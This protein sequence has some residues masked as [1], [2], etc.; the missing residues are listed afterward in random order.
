CRPAV[1]RVLR[2]RVRGAG[3]RLAHRIPP[4]GRGDVARR[5]GVCGGCGAARGSGHRGR[6]SGRSA[7]VPRAGAPRRGRPARPGP[8][9]RRHGAR[10]A[11]GH[12]G[13][14]RSARLRRGA[15]QRPGGTDRRRDGR[16]ARSVSGPAAV[17]GPW[18]S[19]VSR[20]VP[21]LSRS[22]RPR[23]RP[24]GETAR[25]AAAR[26]PRRPTPDAW[27]VARRRLPQDHDRSRRHGH[28]AVRGDALARGP[29]GGGD[30]PRDAACGKRR[31][32]RGRGPV[33]R[34]L[35]VMP[36]RQ[37][38]RRR[39]AR[40]V[41]L[42][43]AAGAARP[44]GPSALQRRRARGADPAGTS[45]VAGGAGHEELDAI[46]ARLLS[47]LERAERLVADRGSA[48]NL[49]MESFVLLLREGF[50]AILLVA[51][52]MTFLAKAGAVERR[53]HVAQG[54]WAAVGA[55][56]IT[57]VVIELLFQITPGER[58]ALEGFTML[59]AT[60]VLFYVSY[61][62]VSKIEAAKWSAFVK[63]RMEEALSA[64]SGWALASVAFLAVYREGFETILFYKA[65]LTSAGLGGRGGGTTAVLGGVF[66][67]A[68]ALV[69]VYIGINRF[70]LK[71]PL[72]PFFAITS[73]MLYYMAFVFA[74]KGIA[75]L[76]EA[77]LVKTTVLE[78]APRIP[79]L[80]IYPTL[81]SLS[82]QFLL[83]ALLLVAIVWLQR[84]RLTDGG[85]RRRAPIP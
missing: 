21:G 32:A 51:A 7:P 49:F 74:G 58:E 24:E 82:L 77:G 64:G 22:G 70:G 43:A 23:R 30:L 52:L 73:A 31:G 85:E 84:Q 48:A 15:S 80:G 39:A 11:P 81:Q 17:T 16:R 4:R 63:S 36:R 3:E 29:L 50:E 41:A 55:S 44:R 54:A 61:W 67:G 79:V 28:A 14:Y 38:G 56:V 59:L 76:Q 69:L 35:R 45:R 57:A 37:R 66:V 19:G 9:R 33:R 2:D 42:G 68:A 13:P 83:L 46:H 60:A 62:L 12:G 71:V 78:W 40:R 27:R 34:V 65:L 53:R 18:S 6:R 5:Q 72:K 75:D 20:S 10:A 8:R 47:G 26:E 25:G 1:R